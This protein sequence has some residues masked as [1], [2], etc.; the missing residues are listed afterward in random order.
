LTQVQRDD[1][2][3]LNIKAKAQSNNSASFPTFNSNSTRKSP[4]PTT[5]A[6]PVP[7]S[8]LCQMLSNSHSHTPSQVTV[9]CT[10][11]MHRVA[12]APGALIDGGA[13][14]GHGVA[15]VHV[16][17]NTMRLW[18]SPAWVTNL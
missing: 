11:S 15:D 2:K 3:E 8:A 5:T 18:T 14:G 9:H 6:T 7:G 13:T 1:L 12:S 10:Y 16:I 4:P 17:L